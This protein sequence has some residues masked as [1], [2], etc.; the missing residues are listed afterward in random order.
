[1]VIRAP[2]HAGGGLETRSLTELVDVYPTVLD[3][4]GLQTE[5]AL[6]GISLLPLFENPAAPFKNSSFSQYPRCSQ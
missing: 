4:L 1:M 3:M 2:W 5:E 6:E